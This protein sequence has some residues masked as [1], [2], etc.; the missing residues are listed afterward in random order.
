MSGGQVLCIEE[1]PAKPRSNLAVTGLYMYGSDVFDV[2]G[3]L[4]PS[5]GVNLR[6][7]M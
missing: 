5:G 1:A 7:R 6:S 3:T 2:I 4:K